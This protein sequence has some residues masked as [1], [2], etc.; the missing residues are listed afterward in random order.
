MDRRHRTV[1]VQLNAAGLG[2]ALAQALSVP[3]ISTHI[4][5]FADTESDVALEQSFH[6]IMGQEV[7]LVAQVGGDFAAWSINDFLM[8]LYFL[9]KRIR[10]A[11]AA[12][13]RCVLPY[14]PYARQDIEAA[15]GGISCAKIFGDMLSAAGVDAVITIDLHNPQILT[16]ISLPIVNVSSISFWAG[17]LKKFM[18]DRGRYSYVLVAPDKGAAVR[19]QALAQQLEI[20]SCFVAKHRVEIDHA[21]AI[22]ISGDVKGRYALILDDI[23]D[24][25]RTAIGAAELVLSRGAVGVSAFFT[26][27]VLSSIS[28]SVMQKTPFDQ[29]FVTEA[30]HHSALNCDMIKYVSIA[31]F[32]VE[33]VSKLIMQQESRV[34]GSV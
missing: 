4:I 16:Q 2:E 9:V 32:I 25:G 33:S 14:F 23:I 6:S 15:H 17:I 34:L 11:G 31:P 10:S 30:I 19:V 22:S 8:S 3:L 18:Q 7:I 13:L 21:K 28:L 1:V 27:A 29:I 24:T 20:E 26:H 12:S 5:R